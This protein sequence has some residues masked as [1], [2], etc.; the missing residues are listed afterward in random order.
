MPP[1][2]DFDTVPFVQGLVAALG[3][4][5]TVMHLRAAANA[6]ALPN[7]EPRAMRKHFVVP[8]IPSREVARA[9]WSSV[10]HCEDAF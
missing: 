8:S 3:L 10:R 4:V 5:C 9:Q 1:P 7:P 2:A 6:V